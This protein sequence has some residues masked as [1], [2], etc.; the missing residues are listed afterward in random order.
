M[1]DPGDNMIIYYLWVDHILE[2][3]R[4]VIEVLTVLSGSSSG[5]SQT[6]IKKVQ[7]YPASLHSTGQNVHAHIMTAGATMSKCISNSVH[8]P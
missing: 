4:I 8:K 5:P 3:P 7:S 6:G 2:F 1:V